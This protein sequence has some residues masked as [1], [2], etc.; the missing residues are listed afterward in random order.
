M[1]HVIEFYFLSNGDGNQGTRG[2]NNYPAAIELEDRVRRYVIE[3]NGEVENTVIGWIIFWS[4]SFVVHL[5]KQKDN[6]M[7]ILT[8]TICP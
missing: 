5:I 4:D 3:N 7:W 8:A 2:I 6:S 1:A